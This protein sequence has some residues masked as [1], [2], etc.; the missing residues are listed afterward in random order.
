MKNAFHT[1]SNQEEL[2]IK[3]YRFWKPIFNAKKNYK[4]GKTLKL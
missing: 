2:D 3:I 4:K 1:M